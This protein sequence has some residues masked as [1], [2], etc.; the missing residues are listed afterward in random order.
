MKIYFA[1]SI[2][3]GR[4]NAGAYKHLADYIAERATLLT[5]EF[6]DQ[7][8]TADGTNAPSSVIHKNDLD[9]VAK[10]DV[11]IAEVSVPS[12]GVGY[13]I[14][15]AEEL[16]KPILAFY[17]TRSEYKLSAMIEGSENVVLCKYSNLGLALANIDV[18][19]AKHS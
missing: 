19:I 7:N 2:R 11:I 16:G 6:T 8:L 15:K 14:A 17:D 10:A 3:G 9:L 4:Q 1:C 5:E 13:E 18:F 12:L